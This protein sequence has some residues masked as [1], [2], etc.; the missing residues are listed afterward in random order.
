LLD[1]VCGSKINNRYK[2]YA[3]ILKPHLLLGYQNVL[4]EIKRCEETVIF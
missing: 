4:I 1:Y 3:E 2:K